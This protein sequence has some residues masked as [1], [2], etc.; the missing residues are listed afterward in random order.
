MEI[1]SFEIYHV[2]HLIIHGATV[3]LKP[4]QCAYIQR[5]MKMA[6]LES[7]YQDSICIWSPIGNLAK[8]NLLEAIFSLINAL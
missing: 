8:F 3:A 4:R 6:K 5:K 2:I 7:F 1:T